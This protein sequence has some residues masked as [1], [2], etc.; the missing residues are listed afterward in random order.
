[1]ALVKT[2]GFAG[3]LGQTLNACV[4]EGRTD[5]TVRKFLIYVVLM[6]LVSITA[7]VNH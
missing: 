2:A 6:R 4:Q 7:L 3:K 1:M 5:L